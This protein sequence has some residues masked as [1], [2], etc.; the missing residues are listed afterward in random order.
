MIL[1]YKKILG[2][3]ILKIV[4]QTMFSYSIDIDLK[5]SDNNYL[6]ASLL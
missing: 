1:T 2:E 5:T 3:I 4:Q 6:A